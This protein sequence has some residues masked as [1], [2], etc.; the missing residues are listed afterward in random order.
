MTLPTFS[1][2]TPTPSALA[3]LREQA[4]LED[5]NWAASVSGH[6]V[7]GDSGRGC[8]YWEGEETTFCLSLLSPSAQTRGLHGPAQRLPSVSATP[9]RQCLVMISCRGCVPPMGLVEGR[10]QQDSPRY[11]PSVRLAEQSQNTALQNVVIEHPA[12]DSV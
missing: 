9:P 4:L 12:D 3:E 8:I 2:L 1:H 10:Q 7:R 6:H 5:G 11:R